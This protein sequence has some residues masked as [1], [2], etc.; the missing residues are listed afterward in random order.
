MA[1]TDHDTTAATE[2]VR[3]AAALAGVE[4]ISGIEVTAVEQRRDV[5][6]LGYFIDP[7]DPTLAAFLETQRARRIGRVEAVVARLASLGMPVDSASI[8]SG[9]SR[10]SGRAIG[11]PQVARA[12]IAAGYVRDTN[13]AFER[14]LAHGRP[15]FVP[16]AG[17]PV[18]EVIAVIHVAGGVASMAHPGK[19]GLDEL[20]PQFREAGLDALEAYHS[21]HDLETQR[22]YAGLARELGMLTT[23]GSDFHGDPTHGV[24]PGMSP[25][26]LSEWRRL[27]AARS[28]RG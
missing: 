12:M 21:D 2:E 28:G 8:L 4:A 22:R 27:D 5:H 26:P 11:R 23:G 14:W 1:V 18:A 19:T 25:L 3:S 17:A 6:V 7:N 16:R 24:E 15:A 13:E 20:I 9:A 10:E